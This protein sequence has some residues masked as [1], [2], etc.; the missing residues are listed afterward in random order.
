MKK[1]F[2]VASLSAMVALG[3]DFLGRADGTALY[4]TSDAAAPAHT[5]IPCGQQYAVRCSGGTAKYR[6][7]LAHVDAGCTLLEDGGVDT[8]TA[9][10]AAVIANDLALTADQT[11]D[12]A[13]PSRFYQNACSVSI[14][15]HADTRCDFYRVSPRTIPTSDQV[16]NR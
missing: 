7:C 8:C 6:I 2:V 13:V 12:I 1:L 9:G 11:Y 5:D 16:I 10:C 14:V 15:S 4:L 3:A